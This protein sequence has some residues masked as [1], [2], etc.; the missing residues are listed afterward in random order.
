LWRSRRNLP[1]FV[2]L[3]HSIDINR[4]LAKLDADGYRPLRV[5]AATEQ[6]R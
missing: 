2:P 6:A 1:Q 5:I 3:S 4:E